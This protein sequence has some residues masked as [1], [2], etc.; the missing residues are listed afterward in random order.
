VLILKKFIDFDKNG[1]VFYNNLWL[2]DQKVAIKIPILEE[3]LLNRDL[4]IE[5]FDLAKYTFLLTYY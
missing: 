4:K 5:K 1:R 3:N 2:D